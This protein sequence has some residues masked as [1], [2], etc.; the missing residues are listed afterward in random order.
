MRRACT[1]LLALDARHGFKDPLRPKWERVPRDPVPHPQNENGFMIGATV[2]L[3][4]SHRHRGRLIDEE[5]DG[6]AGAP[7]GGKPR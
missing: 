1:T 5:A 7:G 4:H 3:G 6:D 2:A